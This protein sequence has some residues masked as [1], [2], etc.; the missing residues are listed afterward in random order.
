MCKRTLTQSTKICEYVN[1]S[2]QERGSSFRKRSRYTTCMPLLLVFLSLLVSTAHAVPLEIPTK[3]IDDTLRVERVIQTAASTARSEIEGQGTHVQLHYSSDVPVEVFITPVRADESFDPR[4][5]LMGTL[6]PAQEQTV[7]LQ[8]NSSSIWSPDENAYRLTFVSP[9]KSGM[10]FTIVQF[11]GSSLLGTA[12]EQYF[13]KETYNPTVYHR[14][15]GP[16]VFGTSMTF[17]IGILIIVG[18]LL[19]LIT[20]KKHRI[21]PL[22][23]V[24]I[25]LTQFRFS[26]DAVRYTSDHFSEWLRNETYGTTGST[27]GI[28]SVVQELDEPRIKLCTSSTSY[29]PTLLNYALYPV[30]FVQQRPTHVLV[31]QSIDWSYA[32]GVLQCD[33]ER[34]WA[35]EF[36]TFPDGSVLFAIQ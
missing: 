4:D 5:I 34:F 30:Q 29:R 27:Y 22:I 35:E 26:F 12:L 15:R 25:L 24:L 6:P 9:Q 8:L 7:L 16:M 21:L 33:G 3:P 36:Q 13:Q 14:L 31:S 32:A 20:K 17:V 23:V 11:E 1:H 28:A 10:Q 19:L 2:Q 18:A